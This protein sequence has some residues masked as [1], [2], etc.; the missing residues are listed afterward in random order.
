[1]FLFYLE[2]SNEFPHLR[3]FF[4]R[5]KIRSISSIVA[6]CSSS[7]FPFGLAE[8]DRPPCDRGGLLPFLMV[9]LDRF[10][11]DDDRQFLKARLE[12]RF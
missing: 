11:H 4:I 5:R 6:R 1:M 8:L 2:I 10:L 7:R 9:N 3:H 12:R